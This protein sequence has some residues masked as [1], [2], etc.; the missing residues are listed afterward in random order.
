MTEVMGPLI[1]TLTT[2]SSIQLQVFRNTFR[3]GFFDRVRPYFGGAYSPARALLRK[4]KILSSLDVLI[5]VTADVDLPQ[6]L[7]Q[8]DVAR[9][10]PNLHIVAIVHRTQ[11]FTTQPRV[12]LEYRRLKRGQKMTKLAKESILEQCANLSISGRL[13]WLTLSPHVATKLEETLRGSGFYPTVAQLKVHA[14]VPVSLQS[15]RIRNIPFG[16]C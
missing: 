11:H 9:K 15:L 3:A 16:Q 14:F 7:D 4:W 2:I 8:V 5:L 13:T 1:Y 6:L 12:P 10:L